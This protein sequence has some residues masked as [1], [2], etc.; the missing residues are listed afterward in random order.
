MLFE[1]FVLL[2]AVEDESVTDELD[3]AIE[4]F[5]SL[6]QETSVNTANRLKNR[7]IFFITYL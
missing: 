2:E 7:I 3:F 5:S 1:E 4:D 6:A